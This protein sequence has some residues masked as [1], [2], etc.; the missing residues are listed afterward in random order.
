MTI[1]KVFIFLERKIEILSSSWIGFGFVIVLWADDCGPHAAKPWGPCA[2]P[3]LTVTPLHRPTF[4][5]PRVP[6]RSFRS[7][8][9]TMVKSSYPQTSP[10][11]GHHWCDPSDGRSD[12]SQLMFFWS[13]I[14]TM[15]GRQNLVGATC[16]TYFLLTNNVGFFS[17]WG[18]SCLGS[19]SIPSWSIIKCRI[20]W[21]PWIKV[22]GVSGPSS[23]YWP[24]SHFFHF[25]FFILF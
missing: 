17:L 10:K 18:S 3:H 19:L 21:G 15:G 5:V 1:R 23:P 24:N 13:E 8:T 25:Y 7:Q 22:V 6:I 16:G 20:S 9:L 14:F 12:G 2:V 11:R 4:L